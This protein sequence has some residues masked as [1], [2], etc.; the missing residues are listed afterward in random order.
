MLLM[1][2]RGQVAHILIVLVG[3]ALF[4]FAWFSYF[5]FDKNFKD[6]SLEINE[7]NSDLEFAQDYVKS[8]AEVLLEE[9]FKQCQGC[10]KERLKR[11]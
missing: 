5:G 11:K 8:S 2:R 7:L 6:K 9:T 3:L 10:D 4:A 1:N